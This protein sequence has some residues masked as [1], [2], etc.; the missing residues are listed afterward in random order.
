MGTAPTPDTP[1]RLSEALALAFPNGGMT[2]SGLRRERDKGRLLVERIAG[3]EFT[4]LAAIQ[5]MRELCRSEARDLDCGSSPPDRN[6]TAAPSGL[7]ETA[8][9]SVALAL[10]RDKVE[11]LKG[12]S[13]TT[14]LQNPRSRAPATVIRLKSE[15][16]T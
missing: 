5:R 9:S 11:K 15:S 16:L 12:L 6:K 10:A 14:S 8:K 3:R 2:V 4:T 1:L 13:P 7:S